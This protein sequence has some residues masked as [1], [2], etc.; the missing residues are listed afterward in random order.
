MKTYRFLFTLCM[1]FSFLMTKAQNINGISVNVNSNQEKIVVVL[2]G[3]PVCEGTHSCF[4]A[5]LYPGTYKIQVFPASEMDRHITSRHLLY[6]NK[7]K[8]N[9]QGVR[10]IQIAGNIC[11]E[12]EYFSPSYIHVMNKREFLDY[13]KSIDDA[14]FDSRRLERIDML[15]NET[16]F[17]SEQCCMLSEVFDFDQ[18]RVSLLKKLYPRVVDKASFYKAIDTMDFLGNQREVKDFVEKYNKRHR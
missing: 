5:N 6:Y 11:N 14:D 9:G 12:E 1:T 8:Y 17:S 3:Q 2:N 16:S 4:I 15:P 7:I 10:T 13:L 18:G